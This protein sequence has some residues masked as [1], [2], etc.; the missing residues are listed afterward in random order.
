MHGNNG[1]AIARDK[2]GTGL[3]KSNLAC[4]Q[5]H[6]LAKSDIEVFHVEHFS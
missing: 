5:Q 2:V 4:R 1:P 6:S 3:K